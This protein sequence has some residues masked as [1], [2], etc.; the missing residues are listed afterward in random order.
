MELIQGF[1]KPPKVPSIE[2]T[3]PTLCDRVDNSTLISDRRS[4]VLGLKAFS[5]EYREAVIASGLKPLIGALNKDFDDEDSTK[6][7]LETLLILFIRGE[8]NEDLTR[9]WISQQSRSQNGKYPSPL[10]MKQEQEQVDQFSLWIAD[11]I[12]QTDKS[13]HLFFQ[14]MDTENFHIRLYAIQLLEAIIVARPIRTRDSI[15]SLPTSISTLVSL[16]D[17]IHEP[18][19]DEAILLLMTVVNNSSHIQKLVAFENIFERLFGIIDSEGGLRGSIVVNDCL[20]LISNILNYNTSNQKLFLEIGNLPELAKLLNEPLSKDEDFFWNEQRI[21]NINTSLDIVRLIVEPG[22][23]VTDL[24]QRALFDSNILMI[25]LRLTFFSKTPNS[26]RPIAMLTACDIIRDNNYIQAQFGSIDVPYWDPSLPIHTSTLTNMPVPVNELLLNWALF[27]NSVHTFN[28]R[29]ASVELL[30]AY[31]SSNYDLQKQFLEVQIERYIRSNDYENDDFDLSKPSIFQVLMSYDGELKLNPYKLFFAS[32]LLI[33]LLNCETNSRDFRNMVRNVNSGTKSLGEEILS[34][35]QTICELL[36]TNLSIEDTRIPISYLNLLIVWL[37]E[38]FDAVNDF[39]SNQLNIRTLVIFASQIYDEDPI[40]KCLVTILLGVAYEFSSSSSPFPRIELYDLLI[41]SLGKDNY[42]SRIKQFTEI[43]LFVRANRSYFN[44]EFD[45]TGLPDIYFTGSFLDLFKENLYVIQS[46]LR[47]NPIDGPNSKVP[48]EE[49]DILKQKFVS[50]KNDLDETIV[51]HTE[52]EQ[53]LEGELQTLKSQYYILQRQIKE[54]EED[55]NTLNK[56]YSSVKEALQENTTKLN[57]AIKDR[58]TLNIAREQAENQLN[59]YKLRL[60]KY[61]EQISSLKKEIDKIT[62]EKLKAE[63]GINKM[64]KEL[65]VL[66]KNNKE[67]ENALK[68]MKKEVEQN[69]E[70]FEKEKDHLEKITCSLNKEI[71]Q[72]QQSIIDLKSEKDKLENS[73]VSLS[74]ELSELKPRLE[75]H[76]SLV[77]KLKDKLKSLATSF[78]DIE[79]E[80]D[81]LSK[82]L[83]IQTQKFESELDNMKNQLENQ[84]VETKS[85][86]ESLQN[87]IKN[88][89]SKVDNMSSEI[90]LYKSTAQESSQRIKE[91]EEKISKSKNSRE[92]LEDTLKSVQIDLTSSMD[93]MNVM[94]KERDNCNLSIKTL[95]SNIS[96]LEE[97]RSAYESKSLEYFQELESLKEKDSK[98]IKKLESQIDYLS[99]ELKNSTIRSDSLKNELD[100]LQIKKSEMQEQYNNTIIGLESQLNAYNANISSSHSNLEETQ[101]NSCDEKHVYSLDTATVLSEREAEF[102]ELKLKINQLEADNDSLRCNNKVFEEQLKSLNDYKRKD[103]SLDI[104]LSK[105]YK[106][107]KDVQIELKREQDCNSQNSMITLELRKELKKLTVEN[108]ITTENILKYQEEI[109]ELQTKLA[110]KDKELTI[111]KEKIGARQ[112]LEGNPVLLPE[113]TNKESII[114]TKS[115][116]IYISPDIATSIN[117]ID[118]TINDIEVQFT[119]ADSETIPITQEE[120]SDSELSVLRKENRRMKNELVQWKNKADDRSEIEDLMLLV[121]ELDEKNLRYRSRLNDLGEHLSSDESDKDES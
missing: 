50:L 79:N 84:I 42:A 82:N 81:T 99:E 24:H 32:D 18:V 88:L 62:E 39:L 49:F 103:E 100:T 30:K 55:H 58:D 37:F 117:G 34:S 83:E 60:K 106:E 112:E 7:I 48:Y 111:T 6:A 104:E 107:L 5:R 97:E 47:R 96:K 115:N 118:D 116:A 21:T 64:S 1:I 121:T 72:L 68:I 12:L 73:K 59:D 98:I 91:L 51:A 31:L 13:I 86:E 17:D 89:N 93:A 77:S 113:Q 41:K 20:S 44:P 46:S 95:K 29:V 8:G 80:R 74:K 11:A 71:V 92:H 70:N 14:L 90:E 105:L 40:L 61:E 45:E 108:E 66:T 52:K 54:S 10:V 2:E 63:N 22:N 19:R 110:S 33:Y 114:D 23:T 43:S 9:H 120:D 102:Q 87:T 78:K 119:G 16:L 75:C 28:I 94:E 38:D 85:L 15:I 53:C 25:I 26:I 65:F 57:D 76:E 67:A 109:Q 56:D 101:K 69:S 36:L 4:A 3:I 35:I 27:S